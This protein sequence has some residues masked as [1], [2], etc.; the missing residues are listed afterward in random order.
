MIKKFTDI[1]INLMDIFSLSRNYSFSLCGTTYEQSHYWLHVQ[2]DK[3]NIGLY[4]ISALLVS[5]SNISYVLSY[6]HR[7]S[8]V[9]IVL[10]DSSIRFRVVSNYSDV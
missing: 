6:K 2:Q 9:Y 1:M 7:Q 10:I 5:L 3:K 4:R 8:L